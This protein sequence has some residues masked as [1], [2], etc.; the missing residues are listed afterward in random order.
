LTIDIQ[1]SSEI[2]RS[3]PMLLPVILRNLLGNAIK[4]TQQGLV[5][6]RVR[7]EGAQL[8]LDVIDSGVGIPEEHLQR[9]FDA[10]YQIDNPNRDQRR[11]IGL[12]LSIVQ[13]ISQL[14]DHPVS[15]ESHLG[16]GSTFSVKV[17]R[18]IAIS[19]SKDEAAIRTPITTPSPNALKVLHIEDDP[20]VARSMAMLLRLE[21]YHVIGAASR[22]EALQRVQ[23]EGL[24][25]DIILCDYQLPAGFTGDEI[26]A[27]LFSLLPAKP[28]TI[29][30]TGD[31][32]DAHAA[33]AMQVADRI[34]PKPINIDILLRELQT[35]M[36]ERE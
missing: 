5:R 18:G 4:Y 28:P 2:A 23:L 21:G 35:L 17:P 30:L 12:G 15:V 20:G 26:V 1:D 7:V 22:D 32:S 24:R 13:R 31:I 27:E 3:D 9:I 29:M 14:L 16:E 25:P 33:R 19:L 11:G 8:H 36:G 10:F 6:L 34:L